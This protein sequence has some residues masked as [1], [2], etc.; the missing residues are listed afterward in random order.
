MK[1]SCVT[2]SLKKIESDQVTLLEFL[3]LTRHQIDTVIL[4]AT[5]KKEHLQLKSI[6]DSED[7]I[8]REQLLTSGLFCTYY[9]VPFLN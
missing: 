3:P 4:I 1:H 8:I 5:H 9:F 7:F 2:R 6:E